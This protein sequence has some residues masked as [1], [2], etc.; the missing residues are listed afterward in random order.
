VGLDRDYTVMVR[1]IGVAGITGP[2]S[3]VEIFRWNTVPIAG[4]EV[5]WPSR[6]MP[7]VQE[8]IFHTNLA[9]AFIDSSYIFDL[10]RVGIHI[11]EFPASVLVE[12]IKTFEV[13]LVG[14]FDPVDFLYTNTVKSSETVFPCVLYR[15]QVTNDLYPTVSGDVAQV[16]PMM[17]DIAYGISGA[18]TT[19][20]DP[21]IG[22]TRQ[23]NE[24][25]GVYLIDTQPVVHGA[26]YQYLIVRFNED[27]KELD[28]IIPA[29]TVT[30]P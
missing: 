23:S 1:A 7:N 13:Q 14:S 9:A 19:I 30:I 25:W 5:P 24:D 15:Y 18:T 2:W 6:G 17:E 16:S 4:P 29:G 12:K 3:N 28:R 8:E 20:Y 21:F 10:N 26:K 22:I 11:G 27:T